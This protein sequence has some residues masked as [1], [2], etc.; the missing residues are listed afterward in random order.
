MYRVHMCYSQNSRN[1]LL[2]VVHGSFDERISKFAEL[3]FRR[4][5]V[6]VRLGCRV[7][8]VSE[9]EI[10]FKDK[11]TGKDIKIPYGMVVWSTGIGT[12]PVVADFMEQIGQVCTDH[13]Y[14]ITCGEICSWWWC[15]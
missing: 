1:H 7:L 13:C 5:G 8:G 10:S 4:D 9:K 15:L 14:G 6:D 2:L 12:R 3:K 11:A